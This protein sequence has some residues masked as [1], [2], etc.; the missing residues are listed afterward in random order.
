MFQPVSGPTRSNCES[1]TQSKFV[2]TNMCSLYVATEI[3]SGCRNNHLLYA[4]Q[5][6]GIQTINECFQLILNSHILLTG[7]LPE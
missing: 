7:I 4:Q 1:G 5:G 3:F 6:F 2:L